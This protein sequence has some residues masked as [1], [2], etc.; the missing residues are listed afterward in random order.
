[1]SVIEACCLVFFA[2]FVGYPN[3]LFVHLAEVT[4]MSDDG[5]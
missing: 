5:F 3:T 2:E 1:M 4:E